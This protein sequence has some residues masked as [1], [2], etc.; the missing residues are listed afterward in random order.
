MA[1]Q[2]SILKKAMIV[3]MEKSLGIVTTAAKSAGINRN[4]HYK[5]YKK[6]KKYRAAVDDISER[7]LDFAESKLHQ[8]IAGIVLP[9]TKVFVVQGK[10]G[11]EI[12][13]HQMQKHYP[14]DATATIFYLKCKGKARGYIEKQQL[15][16]SG[17]LDLDLENLPIIFK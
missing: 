8:L 6:D 7:S 14:P 10:K 5:W 9:E 16:L 17:K 3:A 1:S 2:S 4:T 13:S 11:K 15:E 12:L